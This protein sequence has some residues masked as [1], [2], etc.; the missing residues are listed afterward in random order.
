M[1]VFISLLVG[2]STVDD[3]LD[4]I[5]EVVKSANIKIEGDTG[6]TAFAIQDA[7]P[8]PRPSKVEREAEPVEKPKEEGDEKPQSDEKKDD[9]PI[10]IDYNEMHT[11]QDLLRAIH[12]QPGGR[13]I[14][15]ENAP[16]DPHSAAAQPNTKDT[17]P[18][19]KNADESHETP[20][21]DAEGPPVPPKSILKTSQ[22][23]SSLDT[24]TKIASL[25][26][27]QIHV[28]IEGVRCMDDLLT[29]IDEAVQRAP[30]VIETKPP[31][32]KRT[33]Q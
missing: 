29:R 3:L 15:L 12:R 30:L 1:S 27:D 23:P 25:K 11:I 19:P 10:R 5:D 22:D 33:G 26:D 17:S 2:V 8:T 13:Q 31:A 14:V 28:N 21:S 16:D 7:P 6:N 32:Q 24:S 4:R 20:A 9:E 18:A